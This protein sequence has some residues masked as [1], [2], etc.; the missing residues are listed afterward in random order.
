MGS[1]R[2]RRLRESIPTSLVAFTVTAQSRMKRVRDA[3][4]Y[5]TV[6]TPCVYRRPRLRKEERARAF[7]ASAPQVV[8]GGAA[9]RANTVCVYC[10]AKGFFLQERGM[11]IFLRQ[12]KSSGQFL[13]VGQ[14][15]SHATS[16]GSVSAVSPLQDI[17]CAVCRP[18]FGYERKNYQIQVYS[19]ALPDIMTPEVHYA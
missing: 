9:V 17:F 1:C 11:E 19:F 7:P 10:T 12:A 13:T 8:P 3:A 4:H 2:R 5:N 15:K 16:K 14:M 6:V 18:S